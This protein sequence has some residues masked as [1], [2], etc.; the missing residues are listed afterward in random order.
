MK[1]DFPFASGKKFH[2]HGWQ[3]GIAR[4]NDVDDDMAWQCKADHEYKVENHD[5]LL[6]INAM[7]NF[8]SLEIKRAHKIL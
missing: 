3:V 6:N 7:H 2:F 1:I 5:R 8:I 4:D